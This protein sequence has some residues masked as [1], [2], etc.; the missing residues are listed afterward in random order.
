MSSEKVYQLRIDLQYAKPPIWRRVLVPS[1]TTLSDMH[2]VIHALFGWTNSHLHQFFTCDPDFRSREYYAPSGPYALDGAHD[3]ADYVLSQF[4][5]NKGDK[6]IYEYDFGDSWEHVIKLE[7]ILPREEVEAEYDQLPV[8]IKGRLARPLE[9]IGGIGG[10]YYFLEVI[11]DPDHEQYED[12]VGWAD[13]DFDP[14]AFDL[15]KANK[16]LRNRGRYMMGPF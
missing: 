4:L 9:D 16:R 13:G 6:L 1:D 11:E 10:Y 3:E 2:T 5:V 7:K 15:D 8:C 12:Y 14:E